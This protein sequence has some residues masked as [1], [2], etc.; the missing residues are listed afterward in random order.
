M[1]KALNFGFVRTPGLEFEGDI[2]FCKIDEKFIESLRTKE[3]YEFSRVYECIDGQNPTN[4]KFF[5]KTIRQFIIGNNR[6]FMINAIPECMFQN[7]DNLQEDRKDKSA[8]SSK[9]F[10]GILD[11]MKSLV[12]NVS[13][14]KLILRVKA[15]VWI[16]LSRYLRSIMER[17][18][19]YLISAITIPSRL[20][21]KSSSMMI[22]RA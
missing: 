3:K 20:P 10:F 7:C 9:I 12:W 16:Y 18:R 4:L 14:P 15:E 11:F 1:K 22:L 8:L 21:R 5:E 2:N 6:N 17:S 13:P 19:I